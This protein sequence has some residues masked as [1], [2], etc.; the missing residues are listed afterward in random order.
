MLASTRRR[1]QTR[2]TLCAALL[3]S[4]LAGCANVEAPAA[5][6]EANDLT[7]IFD[8][9]DL[10]ENLLEKSSAIPG[11]P[12]SFSR[13]A[14]MEDSFFLNAD[15]VDT[16]AVQAFFERGPYDGARS[17]LAD[18]RVSGVSAASALV[19]A[20]RNEGLNPVLLVARMQVEK[21]LV[22]LARNPG[23]NRVD[24]AFGC[25]CPDNRSCN[26]AY[27]G[28]DKQLACA[29]R[30]LRRGYD[31][32][33]AGDGTFVKGRANRTLDP[34]TLTPA[35]HA[36]ASL[37]TY[38]PW[39]Q[40]GRGGNWLVWNVTLRH[41]RHFASQGTL[42]ASSGGNAGVPAPP[43][44]GGPPAVVH[45]WIGDRCGA[46]ADCD[47]GDR[48]GL[49]A[50]GRC[51]LSCEGLC[52]DRAGTAPTF[53]VDS[54]LFGISGGGLCAPQADSRNGNCSDN[55][56]NRLDAPR[57]VGNSTASA[58]RA[59]VCVPAVAENLG[60]GDPGGWEEPEPDPVPTPDPAPDAD[61]DDAPCA[62]G[63]AW[64]EGDVRVEC[65][66]TRPVRFDCGLNGATCGGGRCVAA[67]STPEPEPQPAADDCGQLDTYGSCRGDVAAR[68]ING[69][70]V[71]EDC[72]RYGQA[73][74]F[75][76][77]G[78]ACAPTDAPAGYSA[79]RCAGLGFEGTCEGQFAVWCDGDALYAVHCAWT[80]RSCG[81]ADDGDG[82]WCR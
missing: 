65:V 54:V 32:S 56:L 49:C 70:V 58:R 15:A 80:G 19:T 51:A 29:A 44:S 66:A 30:T 78:A 75:A 27:R 17:F 68:C 50:S 64:C 67:A 79:N 4:T 16:A 24:Y 73:C 11:L 39:V 55:D 77:T 82:Y 1:I 12:S 61:P 22:S 35:N 45:S 62:S 14:V 40:Q 47:F 42:N 52:P 33:V 57:Y 43:A 21:G 59:S 18:L 81:W 7:E 72:S 48:Q 8:A 3:V 23:G 6:R 63:T 2:W 9:R 71:S 41:A 46:D 69:Q 5:A 53:C 76:P 60:G 37:Y 36:T 28:L 74:D 20:A 10:E 31:D 26:S 38:T 13:T 34:I 25:G